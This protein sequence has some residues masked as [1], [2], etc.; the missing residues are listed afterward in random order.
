MTFLFSTLLLVTIGLSLIYSAGNAREDLTFF[1]KQLFFA[2]LGFLILL[3]SAFVSTRVWYAF[4][5]VVFGICLL[6]LI[7]VLISG[8]IGFGAKRWISIGGIRIQPSEPA[9]IGFILVIARFLADWHSK[10]NWKMVSVILG[11]TI[12]TTIIILIQ[13]DLGTSSVFPVIAFSM[14]LWYGL[15]IKYFLYLTIPAISIFFILFPWLVILSV[16]AGLA[17]L[18]KQGSSWIT[19][20]LIFIICIG[21]TFV[22]PVVWKNLKPYQKNRINTFLDPNKDPLGSGYQVI[23]SRI[24]IGSGGFSG[25]GFLNG[26]QTQLRFLPQQHTDFIFSIAGEEFGFI[27]TSFILLLYFSLVLI[28]FN[29]ASTVKNQFVGLSTVGLITMITYHVVVNIGM[30]MGDL[31]VTGLPIPFLSYGGSF[32]ITC[33][34]ASGMILSAGVYKRDY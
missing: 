8:I 5:Y 7:Y 27:G 2:S 16:L 33:M 18:K 4:A 21:S 12:P 9:K 20:T 32:L 30:V 34:F 13:P 19:I 26:T 1:N 6:L 23:Q 31:P 28:A 10:K 22:A 24:A 11:I 14:L 17:W 3:S 25:A 15:P 29:I